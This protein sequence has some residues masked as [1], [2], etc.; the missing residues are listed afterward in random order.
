MK[1]YVLCNYLVVVVDGHSSLVTVGVPL[2]AM[3]RPRLDCGAGNGCFYTP[4]RRFAMHH[5]WSKTSHDTLVARQPSETR[6]LEG[7]IR[8]SLFC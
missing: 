6:K 3:L 7:N 8:I 2:Q 1:D 5:G 4:L